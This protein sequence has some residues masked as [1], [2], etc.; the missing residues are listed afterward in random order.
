MLVFG[1]AISGLRFKP[2]SNII[3][4]ITR[5]QKS[6]RARG[7]SV[8]RQPKTTPPETEVWVDPFKS[9][10]PPRQ[11]YRVLIRPALFTA[12]VLISADDV[13]D[14]FVERRTQHVNSRA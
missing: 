10:P 12:I 8:V 6:T 5:L 7:R 2:C 3:L 11:D 13:A 1:A 9:P 4:K 14:V